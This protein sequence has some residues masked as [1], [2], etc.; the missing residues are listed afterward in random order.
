MEDFE[1]KYQVFKEILEWI[2]SDEAKERFE[3]GFDE[4]VN[5]FATFEELDIEN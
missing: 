2:K 1:I 5:K 3:K 4:F